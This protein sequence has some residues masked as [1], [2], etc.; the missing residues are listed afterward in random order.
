MYKWTLQTIINILQMWLKFNLNWVYWIWLISVFK[1]NK[2]I[3]MVKKLNADSR[4][5][6]YRMDIAKWIIN[7][8]GEEINN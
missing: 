4:R 8:M 5:E 6:F 1:S 7:K 3:L 2:E